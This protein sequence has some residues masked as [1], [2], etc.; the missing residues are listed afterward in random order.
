MRVGWKLATVTAKRRESPTLGSLIKQG[1]SAV[2]N[3]WHQ[4]SKAVLSGWISFCWSQ[5]IQSV[6]MD[7]I[8]LAHSTGGEKSSEKG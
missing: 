4:V 6:A 1:I 3:P 7:V 2:S 5:V 8:V